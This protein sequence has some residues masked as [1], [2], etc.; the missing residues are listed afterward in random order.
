MK[1][2]ATLTLK[3]RFELVIRSYSPVFFFLYL[4]IRPFALNTCLIL[5]SKL[6][7]KVLIYVGV[8]EVQISS[9]VS[10]VFVLMLLYVPL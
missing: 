5:D 4:V 6:L 8:M 3:K 10:K 2:N 1:L 7:Y 9:T